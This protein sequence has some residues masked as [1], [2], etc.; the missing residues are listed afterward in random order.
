MSKLQELK[1]R[2]SYLSRT[3]TAL[4]KDVV[5]VRAEISDI[6]KLILQEQ[7]SGT[8]IITEHSIVR[9]LERRYGLED[10]INQVKKSL[11]KE[12]EGCPRDCKKRIDGD[13]VAII[14]D[15]H[16]VSIV[17]YQNLSSK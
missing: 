16:L 2:K 3:L 14:K 13:L 17:P 12:L 6:H 8:I 11:L 7:K 15:G 1:D 10:T 5:K 9:I 4:E